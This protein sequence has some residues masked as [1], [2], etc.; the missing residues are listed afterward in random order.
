M[1]M[2]HPS[3]RFLVNVCTYLCYM[4]C[5]LQFCCVYFCIL[6]FGCV[7][8]MLR[9]G[10]HLR[11]INVNKEKKK[12]KKTPCVYGGVEKTCKIGI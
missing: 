5:L 9:R 1:H 4:F 8:I 3:K 10:T 7:A 6:F 2:V 12:K 11:K